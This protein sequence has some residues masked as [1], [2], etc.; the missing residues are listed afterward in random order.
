MTAARGRVNVPERPDES[1]DAQ[2]LKVLFPSAIAVAELHAGV[3]LPPSGRRRAG[4]LTSLET[5]LLALF[6]GRMR[7]AIWAVPKPMQN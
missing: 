6:A 5:H 4:L 2:P 7:P 1:I 3:A